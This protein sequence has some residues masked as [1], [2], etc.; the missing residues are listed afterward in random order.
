MGRNLLLLSVNNKILFD[1]YER[2]V[3]MPVR[4]SDRFK[5]FRWTPKKHNLS[6]WG[7][8]ST[9]DNISIWNT[10]SRGDVVLFYRNGRYF[11]KGAIVG[12]LIDDALPKNL[13]KNEIYGTS[14]RHLIF[15]TNVARI[16]IDFKSTMN[17]FVEPTMPNFFSYPA[18][19]VDK[20][21]LNMLIT[22]F[23]SVD[24]AI[25]AISQFQPRDEKQEL[26][27]DDNLRKLPQE[28][29]LR[30][31]SAIAKR[32]KGQEDFRLN[33]LM[34]YENRCSVCGINDKDLLEAAHII[35]VENFKFAGLPVNGICF[36]ILHHAMFDKGYFSIDKNYRIV[37]SD[38]IKRKSFLREITQEGTLIRKAKVSPSQKFLEFHRIRFGF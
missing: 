38:K 8:N 29:Q 11:S 16:N 19:L 17:F 14:W 5:K 33:V 22:T 7:L 35:P 3:R 9:A 15:L 27:Q 10:I 18:K 31:I 32:R 34:N 30:L 28:V 1:N 2:T 37:L 21:K 6:I 26:I 4:L 36:C 23:G 13:W 20:V 12:K 24:N 25:E